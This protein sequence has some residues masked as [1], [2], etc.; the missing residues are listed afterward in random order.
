MSNNFATEFPLAATTSFTGSDVDAAISGIHPTANR[1]IIFYGVD[2]PTISDSN[3]FG[4]FLWVHPVDRVVKYL[5][6]G[7]W[8]E[9]SADIDFDALLVNTI[10]VAKLDALPGNP[11][12][13]LTVV[14][15]FSS[16]EARWQAPASPYAI[17]A[18]KTFLKSDGAT[19]AFDFVFGTDITSPGESD[20]LPLLS[21]GL[22]GCSFDTL[23]YAA[24]PIPP[25]PF[26]LLVSRNDA[27]FIADQV[28]LTELRSDTDLIGT[29][30]TAGHLAVADGAGAI[31][32]IALED[33]INNNYETPIGS[34]IAL[35]VMSPITAGDFNTRIADVI[36]Y[37]T[38]MPM[39]ITCF[40]ECTATD[41]SYAV[42][43][44]LSL[45][46]LTN[47]AGTRGGQF[48]TSYSTGTVTVT[49]RLYGFYI[50]PFAVSG[51]SAPAALDPSKWSVVVCTNKL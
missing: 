12:D 38:Q 16:K 3:F 35:S 8:T 18:D 42:G 25:G 34:R 21:N 31:Q 2:A 46:S 19:A 23:P 1:G 44:R 51:T 29:H 33:M 13:V 48:Y 36:T 20:I 47:S 5:Y 7:T 15:T 39:S 28:N 17:G 9:I 32:W 41:Q 26:K 43:Q 10:A 11:G 40:V 14:S 37:T 27:A 22:G 24:L 49:I 4:L 45:N 30:V 6:E 50:E